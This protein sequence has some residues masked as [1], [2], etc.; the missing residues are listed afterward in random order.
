MSSTKKQIDLLGRD[1]LINLGIKLQIDGHKNFFNNPYLKKEKIKELIKHKLKDHKKMSRSNST[2]S[3]NP[4]LSPSNSNSN[5]SPS[6]SNSNSNSNSS[7]IK[8]SKSLSSLKKR[9]L[10]KN[11]SS[12][13]DIIQ[14]Y[15]IDRCCYPK[16]KK[17]V[18]IGDIH[19]DLSVAIKALKLAGVINLSIPDDTKDITAISWTGGSTY[20]VQLG[21]QIDR[22]RPN[23]L[24]NNLCIEEDSELCDDE[25]SD[26]KIIYLFE[27][28]HKEAKKKGGALFSVFGNHEL[29]NVDGDFRYVSPKEFYEFG[30]FFKGQYEANSKFPYGYKERLDAFKP[31]GAV[32][33]RLALSR[34]SVIQIGSWVFVHGGISPTCAEKYSLKE[35]NNYVKNW[36]LGDNRYKPQINDIFYNDNDDDSPFW[37]RIYSDLDEWSDQSGSTMFNNS[38]KLLNLKNLRSDTNIIKGMIMGHSPQ[39]MYNKGINS[40]NN[41]TIWRVDI[42]AS[43]A[44]GEVDDSEECK[45]RKVQVLIINNDNEFAIVKE[46]CD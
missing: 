16:V 17:L 13:N 25:G 5:I 33:K 19:G 27:K 12:I 31:G 10:K 28:L 32:S 22:V 40:A 38:I 18:A 23:K 43:R 42:G 24:F 7:G 4:S 34:Y 44:F 46:K 30:N 39:F 36:L 8:R 1:S 35:I 45:H 37:S 9:S 6:N 15:D 41:D 14:I 29:M 26:L 21:D 2:S 3:F 11:Y 20:V